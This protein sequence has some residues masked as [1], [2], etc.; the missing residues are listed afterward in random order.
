M[1]ASSILQSLGSSIFGSLP[2][3]VGNTCNNE[4]SQQASRSSI[5][6][7][8]LGSS[9][10]GSLPWSSELLLWE[11][12][13]TMKLHSKPRDPPCSILPRGLR[14]LARCRPRVILETTKLGNIINNNLTCKPPPSIPGGLR[15][16]L[17]RYRCPWP[18]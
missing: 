9:I 15:S 13:A 2:I 12:H 18:T 8:S 17:A 1:Q 5:Q 4:A 14:S 11:I 6:H 7:P 16:S 3:I 10:F